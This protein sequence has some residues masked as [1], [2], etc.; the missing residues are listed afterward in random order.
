MPRQEDYDMDVGS[1]G[2][3]NSRRFASAKNVDMSA[4]MLV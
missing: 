4:A 1:A 2:E 3:R